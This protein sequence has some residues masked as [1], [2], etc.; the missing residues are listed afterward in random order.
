MVFLH[1]FEMVQHHKVGIDHPPAG[2]SYVALR[3]YGAH[4]VFVGGNGLAEVL[5]RRPVKYRLGVGESCLLAGC[6]FF[7]G[8]LCQYIG[9]TVGT[10][11]FFGTGSMHHKS[12]S[13]IVGIG[14]IFKILLHIGID[15]VLLDDGVGLR[16][17]L[18]GGVGL[19]TAGSQQQGN[20]QRQ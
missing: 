14:I 20:A 9:G 7:G 6:H 15:G 16:D 10:I 1:L 13:G 11:I 4:A 18:R 12:I 5:H 19:I 8:Q 17:R 2:G 3:R